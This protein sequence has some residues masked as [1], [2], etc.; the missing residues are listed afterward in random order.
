MRVHADNISSGSV[1]LTIGSR[2]AYG[3]EPVCES[4]NDRCAILG[5]QPA[6]ESTFSHVV[7]K[8]VQPNVAW[9]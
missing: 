4:M 8:F 3:K 9:P 6:V 2:P 5:Q 7:F 1:G